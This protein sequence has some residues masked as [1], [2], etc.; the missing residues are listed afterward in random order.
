MKFLVR[1]ATALVF[2]CLMVGC[3]VA[4]PVWFLALLSL[5]TL[6][7]A[8]EFT[9]IVNEGKGTQAAGAWTAIASALLFISI[10][11]WCMSAGNTD[12]TIP[13]AMSMLF[14]LSL[15]VILIEELF[16]KKKSPLLDMAVSLMALSYIAL[17]YSLL[18]VIAYT[19]GI[20]AAEY[21]FSMPLALFIFIWMNDVGA[22]CTG[23][24]IGKHKL[25]ERVSP[26]KTW[27]GSIGGAVFAV[28]S[29]LVLGLVFP[30]TF[31]ELSLAGWIGMALTVVIFGTLGDLVESLIKRELGIKD[32]GHILPGH[33]G[34][35]DRFDSTLTSAPAAAIYVY[36]LAIL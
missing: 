26:K 14:V 23:C 28:A 12:K 20:G 34:M 4:G 18:F 15:L 1:T 17:P 21:S 32:S 33:G 6:L 7:S 2:G 3:T 8:A 25:F 22:Y 27:E 11:L 30:E 19:P 13:L 10:G 35:L 9:G 16:L 31:A 36:L 29:A 24:T 5:V